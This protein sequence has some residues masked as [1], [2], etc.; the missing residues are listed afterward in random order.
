MRRWIGSGGALL[1]VPS[2]LGVS[3]EAYFETTMVHGLV[4]V[5]RLS[6]WHIGSRGQAVG[7]TQLGSPES[8][9]LAGR[10][11]QPPVFKGYFLGA[12]NLRS[13]VPYDQIPAG[14]DVLQAY[15][16][17]CQSGLLEVDQS[18]R[19]A[20]AS[21]RDLQDRLNK[22]E[23]AKT[24]KA[25]GWFS[26]LFGSEQKGPAT[27]GPRG[28]YLVGGPGA[29]KSMVMD[30]F[31]HCIDSDQKRRVHFHEYML[32]VHRRIHKLR[33][34]GTGDPL[35]EIAKETA[36]QSPLLCFDEF[37]VTD[38]ADAMI[39]K[40]LLEVMTDAG[41]VLVTTS[42]RVPD[43]LYKNGLQRDLFLPCIALIKERCL[44]HTFDKD[45]KDYRLTGSAVQHAADEHEGSAADAGTVLGKSAPRISQ[46][47]MAPLIQSTDHKMNEI[48][49]QL[50]DGRKVTKGFVSVGGRRI[51][52][53]AMAG[54]VARMH[55]DD[56]CKE[57]RGA[58]DYLTI[59]HSFHTILLDQVPQMTMEQ[60]HFVRRLITFVDCLYERRC[61]LICTADTE[62]ENV[63]TSASQPRKESADGT[64]SAKD[65]VQKD[66]EFAWART[67]SRLAEMQTSEYLKAPWQGGGGAFLQ[68]VAVEMEVLSEG[69]M[70]RVWDKYDMNSDGSIDK[71]EL[72]ELMA[73][74]QEL[75]SD[76]RNVPEEWLESAFNEMD[77]NCDGKISWAEFQKYF[78]DRRLTALIQV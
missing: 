65:Y 17:F 30:L 43:D 51:P 60:L 77:I 25:G 20:V 21:L 23:P 12:R 45:C 38:V 15:D 27:L 49:E 67:A 24:P 75:R 7:C 6:Q 68:G 22:H 58:S 26:Q 44:V 19:S 72:A 69:N 1:R 29:G 47:W 57:P 66:E 13:G 61:K 16:H 34:S 4:L 41:V 37:Q 3:G 28:L 40:R 70:F 59:S 42:N 76:H 10:R 8:T 78:Q 63:F 50:V 11:Q 31:Y 9:S 32:D 55:F 53:S 71:A 73:D 74:L 18:Q 56:M 62:I 33:N 36:R 48:F 2:G 5:R 52:I 64:E 46:V 54:G 39:L 35:V 14:Q